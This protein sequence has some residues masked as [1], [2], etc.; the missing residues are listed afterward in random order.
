MVPLGNVIKTS[1][2]AVL[3][4][5]GL[6]IGA[7]GQ[8]PGGQ[9]PF[10]GEL[11]AETRIKGSVVCVGCSLE[12]AQKA[13]PDPHRLYELRHQQGVVVMNVNW[14]SEPAR[15]EAIVGLSHRLSARAEDTV[16][17]QLTTEKNLFKQVEV[18]GLLR[19]DTTFDIGSVTV[20]E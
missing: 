6:S 14:V 5:V 4:L 16:F 12:E 7:H 9:I 10:G 18:V 13:Q 3:L 11:R 20:I 8:P 15:W 2:G 19:S 17:Q 1:V